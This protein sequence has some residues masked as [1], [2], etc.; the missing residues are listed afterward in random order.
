MNDIKQ[1]NLKLITEM[2][3]FLLDYTSFNNK[4]QN[5]GKSNSINET[6]NKTKKDLGNTKETISKK[7]EEFKNKAAKARHELT[8]RIKY[9][10]DDNN[11]VGSYFN[12]VFKFY[13]MIYEYYIVYSLKIINYFFRKLKIELEA[14]S[15]YENTLEHYSDQNKIMRRS[16]MNVLKSKEFREKWKEF[17]LVMAELVGELLE[18]VKVEVKGELGEIL[19]DVVALMYKNVKNTVFGVGTGVVDGICAVPPMLP[20]CEAMVVISTG[21]KL[22]SETFLTFLRTGSKMADSFNKVFGDSAEG[23]AD[24]I[25]KSREMYKTVIDLMNTPENYGKKVF[26]KIGDKIDNYTPS[27]IETNTKI[28][29]KRKTRKNKKTLKRHTRKN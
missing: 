27:K 1:E 28:G 4:Y 18:K 11:I 2:N 5:G 3:D 22:T 29:G 6:I 17:T 16:I 20:F 24:T 14:F 8:E 13:K 26:N 12:T 10:Q 21:S 7:K 19:E 25:N 9:Y 23:I 15:G